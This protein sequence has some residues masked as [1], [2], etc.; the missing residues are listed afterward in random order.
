L[1]AKVRIKEETIWK[2]AYELLEGLNKLHESNIIHRDIK[3]ANVFFHNGVAQLGD[4]NVAKH[5]K[6]PFT[7]TQTGTPYYA[8]PEVWNEEPY[9]YKSDIWSLGTVLY[10]MAVLKP[11]FRAET[12]EKLYKKILTGL[13]DPLPSCYSKELSDFIKRLLIINQ[14]VRPSCKELLCEPKMMDMKNEHE[15]E[16]EDN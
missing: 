11:P 1:N 8:S 7:V 6:D 12:P 2:V 4:L 13:Y 14:K 16:D 3:P 9:D 5:L 15:L 10:E